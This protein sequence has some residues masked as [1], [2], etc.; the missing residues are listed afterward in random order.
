MRDLGDAVATG[1]TRVACNAT[2]GRTIDNTKFMGECCMVSHFAYGDG[3]MAS[4][5]NV[6]FE[7]D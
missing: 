5:W 3:T 7:S 6:Y 4:D 1:A 2:M